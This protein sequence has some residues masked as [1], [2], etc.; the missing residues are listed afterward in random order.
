[1]TQTAQA[2]ASSNAIEHLKAI[3]ARNAGRIF[4]VDDLSG[5]TLTFDA[6]DAGARAVAGFLAAKGFRKGDRIAMVLPNSLPLAQIYFGCLYA[7]IV[8]VP[9]NPVLSPPEAE[10]IV[11]HCMAKALIASAAT[12][13]RVSDGVSKDF[14]VWLLE[15]MKAVRRSF[16]RRR[17]GDRLHV[18]HH[19][20]TERRRAP[21]F[22]HDRQR[23]S[24]RKRHRPRPGQPFLQHARY[25]VPRRLLQFAG[26][27]IRQ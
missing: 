18:R 15:D 19:G 1:M 23:A 13:D 20:R 24:V 5:N 11:R 16:S 27:A 10:F 25:D 26:A 7:G 9:I 17:S 22:R 4:L 2:K 6:L 21:H 12:R 8:V 14:P 3:P